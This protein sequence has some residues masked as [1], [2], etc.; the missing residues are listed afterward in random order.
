MLPLAAQPFAHC[1]ATRIE[2]AGRVRLALEVADAEEGA[3]V[4]RPR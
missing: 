2:I 3:A 1:S 4:T